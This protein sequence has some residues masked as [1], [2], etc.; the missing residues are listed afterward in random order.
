M[1]DPRRIYDG[2]ALVTDTFFSRFWST[3][4]EREPLWHCGLRRAVRPTA[5][6]KERERAYPSN[7]QVQFQTPL[8][9]VSPVLFSG[10]RQTDSGA[11][12][13]L[14]RVTRTL[15]FGWLVGRAPKAREGARWMQ[16]H[17]DFFTTVC[18]QVSVFFGG[19]NLML[20][21]WRTSCFQLTLSHL[22]AHAKLLLEE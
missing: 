14:S 21:L 12:A 15:C 3:R 10:L 7:R 13:P 1:P 9:I 16:F 18:L 4:E 2:V 20:Q 11:F 22:M 5:G 8:R 17:L 19:N 6:G